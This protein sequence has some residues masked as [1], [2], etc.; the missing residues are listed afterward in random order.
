MRSLCQWRGWR[1]R[2]ERWVRKHAEPA[3][4]CW[5]CSPPCYVRTSLCATCSS[6][7]SWRPSASRHRATQ[8]LIVSQR[9]AL[10][11]S[12]EELEAAL[13]VSLVVVAW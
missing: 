10:A 1:R 6:S 12:E 11:F 9:E 3:A 13:C 7:A 4:T 2:H 5:T 8:V